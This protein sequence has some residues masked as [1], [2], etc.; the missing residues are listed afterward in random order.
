MISRSIRTSLYRQIAARLHAVRESKVGRWI[1]R[2]ASGA[3][4][5][6][7]LAAT[8]VCVFGAGL[9][10]DPDSAWR[11]VHQHRLLLLLVT[12]VLGAWDLYQW[13]IQRGDDDGR[14]YEPWSPDPDDGTGDGIYEP[15]DDLFFGDFA[16][17]SAE[18]AGTT[19]RAGAR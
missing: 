2:E 3:T 9:L 16:A 7:L 5:S 19:E 14:W 6:R 11:T 17:W 4:R 18:L 1:R 15:G 13:W 12:G 10:I 8:A